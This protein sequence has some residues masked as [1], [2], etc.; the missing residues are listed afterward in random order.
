M[1][2]TE[3]D[4]VL[5]VLFV[6]NS[7]TFCNDLPGTLA[8]LAGAAEPPTVIE[9]DSSVRG[10]WSLQ[11][12]WAAGEAA[13]RIR[14]GGWDVVVLQDKS[15]GPIDS[16]GPESMKLHAAKFDEKIRL[17]GARTVL[18]M[19]WARQHRR[20]MIETLAREYDARAAELGAT[21]AP[22]G[23]A[24]Q[25]A[26]AAGGGLVLHVEDQSHPNQHGTYLAACVFYAVLTGRDPR[27]LPNGGLTDVPDADAAFLQ[28][29]A[30]ETVQAR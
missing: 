22:V 12:H 16:P 10:G 17:A 30:W 24:W 25:A 15:T 14:E 6:G 19:T 2:E 27:G 5:R 7:Y 18:Y 28:R 21:V 4:A 26:F 8:R 13:R 23:R 11:Q 20:E 1:N 29:V 9:V 3:A